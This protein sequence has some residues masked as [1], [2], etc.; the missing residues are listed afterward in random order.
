VYHEGQQRHTDECGSLP[1]VSVIM[2]VY[3]GERYVVE[4]VES[5]LRQTHRDFEFVIVDDGSTDGTRAI[6]EGYAVRD[7]RIRLIVQDNADQP[8]S[9]NRALAAARSEWV[10]LLDADDVCLPH[11]LETQ[12]RALQRLPSVRV[13][14]SYA[15]WKDQADAHRGM[16]SLG[17]TSI[18]E[19]EALGERDGLIALVHPSVMMHRPTI[20]A[21]GGYDPRF[22]AAADMELW[23]RVSD[24]HAVLS[25]P[26]PLVYYRLH[27]GSMSTARFFE[28]RLMLRWIQARQTMRRQGL[29]PPD[30][31]EYLESQGGR[32]ALRRLEH[33]RADWAEYLNARK[34]L[35]SWGGHRFR[36]L[37]LRAVGTPLDPRL[38]LR[39]R[40]RK[41]P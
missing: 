32:F 17:P 2:A 36:A 41:S 9:L 31:E 13:L 21:L 20:L 5:V 40:S 16:R 34:R 14:G 11:R 30:L 10:A 8:T 4:A 7:G 29:A 3:N 25:V 19:F 1:S 37:L 18:P 35:E 12:L 15:F 38:F 6:L 23:S 27:P 28:Q 22:G 26:E 39:K 33:R 24:E